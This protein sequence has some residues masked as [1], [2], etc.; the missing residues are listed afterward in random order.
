MRINCIACCVVTIAWSGLEHSSWQCSVVVYCCPGTL[1]THDSSMQLHQRDCPAPAAL[2]PLH[3]SI[4]IEGQGD[5]EVDQG[6]DGLDADEE[7]VGL[8]PLLAQASV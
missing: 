8:E 6:D 4:L 5:D 3:Q 2:Q 1:L 7:P